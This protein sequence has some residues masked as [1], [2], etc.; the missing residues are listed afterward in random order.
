MLRSYELDPVSQTDIE[1]AFISHTNWDSRKGRP[2][3]ISGS[4]EL[5]NRLYSSSIFKG[6]TATAGGFYGPQGRVL[7][8]AIQ[9]AE[10]NSKWIILPLRNIAFLILKWKQQPFM[11]CPDY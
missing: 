5:Q 11:D 2:Y 1:D 6:I 7:R 10:L 4:I 3:V 9:D 8:L